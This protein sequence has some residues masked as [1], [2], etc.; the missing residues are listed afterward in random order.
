MKK[1]ISFPSIEQFRNI[2]A[3]INREH[4]FV[5]LDENGE[6]IYDQSKPKPVL[7]FKGT[8]KLHG[9]NFG[10]CFNEQ[11]D[12]WVQSRENIITPEKDNAGSAFFVETNKYAFYQLFKEVSRKYNVDMTENTISIYGEWAGKGIQ[13]GIAISNIEKSLFIFGV[14][15]T[16]HP[17]DEN[18]KTSAYWVDSSFLRN[19]EHK[20]YNI[21]DYK[22]YSIDIDFNTPQL[23][24]NTIIDMTIEVEDE[25]PVGKAFG[26]EGI[27]EGVVF[28]H[29]TSNGKVY[30]FKSKGEKHSK[31]KVK[32]LKPVDDEKIN[33]IIDV[34]NR[35][36]PAWRLEQAMEKTFDLINGGSIDIKRMGDFIRNVV[37]DIMKEELDVIAEA[38][39]EP[40]E[41]NSKVSEISRQ[42]FFA[43]MN[44]E[45]GLN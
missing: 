33:K 13:K 35:V 7:T 31:S 29:M 25:C 17:K 10:V 37:A 9:S 3:N 34:V 16:P 36:T 5:G 6:A 20:I 4:N 24:Q 11:D 39:L 15:I 40:K 44:K 2:V 21:E 32:T 28:S 12:I 30:R 45:V 8:V 22:T 38:G 23:A 26:H 1:H 14:K 18:E 41:I 19:H 42:Y 27:G 43:E